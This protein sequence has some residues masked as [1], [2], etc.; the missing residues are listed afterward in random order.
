MNGVGP[1]TA[2]AARYGVQLDEIEA[3]NPEL[4]HGRIGAAMARFDLGISDPEILSSIAF[5]TTGKANMSVLDKVIYLADII[6]PGRTFLA[7]EN[8]RTLARVDINTAMLSALEQTG[9]NGL[10]GIEYCGHGDPDAFLRRDTEYLR[11]LEQRLNRTDRWKPE[12][13]ARPA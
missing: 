3:Q 6:V 11:W 12:P 9:Y 1:H 2:E 4:A 13:P 10:L 8:I 7:V 5:H